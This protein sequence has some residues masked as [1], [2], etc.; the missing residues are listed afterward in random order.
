MENVKLVAGPTVC[1]VPAYIEIDRN[2]QASTFVHNIGDETSM[3]EKF[4]FISLANIAKIT[5]NTHRACQFG[6]LIVVQGTDN[7]LNV[8]KSIDEWTRMP[9]A[10]P[11][12]SD[13]LS[14]DVF[15]GENGT[16]AVANY[17]T[18]VIED[19][20]VKIL[21]AQLFYIMEQL[22]KSTNDQ[23]V[24]DIKLVTPKDQERI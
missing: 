10:G 15:I 20:T 18:R 6:T 1:T 3:Q 13:S 21:I 12:N 9:H 5:M 2:Q 23:K 24:R 11:V 22:A 16:K 14:L 19:S 8:D 4:N 7:P 17:N